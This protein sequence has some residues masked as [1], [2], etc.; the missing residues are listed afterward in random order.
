MKCLSGDEVV[1]SKDYEEKHFTL[2]IPETVDKVSFKIEGDEDT[3]TYFI[4]EM[5][6]QGRYEFAQSSVALNDFAIEERSAFLSYGKD[7]TPLFK[8]M[9]P[10]ICAPYI[11]GIFRPN[12]EKAVSIERVGEKRLVVTETK[13]DYALTR[14]YKAYGNKVEISTKAKVLNSKATQPMFQFALY[15]L[16]YSMN[17]LLEDKTTCLRRYDPEDGHCVTEEMIFLDFLK[18]G[19]SDKY[20]KQIDLSFETIPN[21]VFRIKTDKAA[22]CFCQLNYLGIEYSRK[23][24]KGQSEID[25]GTITIECID[26]NR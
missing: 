17:I 12:Y 15:D 11:E 8:E 4:G 25:F 21:K 23:V 7:G 9:W 18:Q 19:Y 20:F 10:Y 1:F 24:Y 6:E 26:L 22:K 2:E 5:R 16:S 13:A 14:E 3:Y